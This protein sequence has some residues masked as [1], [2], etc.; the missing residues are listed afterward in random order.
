MICRLRLKEKAKTEAQ[1][2]TEPMA[3]VSKPRTRA[4]VDA[5]KNKRAKAR[6]RQR[7][8][9]ANMSLKKKNARNATRMRNYYRRKQEALN[10]KL[11]LITQNSKFIERAPTYLMRLKAAYKQLAKKRDVLSIT[12][13]A[14]I[15]RILHNSKETS[16]TRKHYKRAPKVN[17][18]VATFYEEQ[19]VDLPGKRS[20]C[21]YSMKPKKVL[22]RKVADV[23]EDF[24]IRHPDVKMSLTTF[25][26]RRPRHVMLSSSRAFL[27][28]L[29]E[30]C[31]NPMLKLDKLN[32]FL[33]VKIRNVDDL[34]E[35]T[36]CGVR[37]YNRDCIDRKCDSCG[38][39]RVVEGWRAEVG[40]NLSKAITWFKWEQS[41]GKGKDKVEKSGTVG[42]LIDELNDEM[43]SLAHHLKT[44]QWQRQQYNDLRENLSPAC[45]VVTIDF[46]E[47]YLCT[48]QNEVQSAHWNYK[49]VSV[50]P[51]VLQYK[52]GPNLITEYKIFLS[53]DL[54]HD[55]AF[56]KFAIQKCCTHLKQ[57]G[58]KQIFLFSDGCSAQYKSK[59]PFAHLTEIA[60]NNPTLTIER[61]FFGSHHGKSLCDSCGGVVKT[62]AT[63]AVKSGREHIQNAEQMFRYCEKLIIDTE[64]E[65]FEK[66]HILRSFELVHTE[67]LDRGVASDTYKT[68]PGTRGLHAIRPDAAVHA[69]LS[70]K[71]FSCFCD[72][73]LQTGNCVNS[74][75]TGMWTMARVPVQTSKAGKRK[76]AP[77]KMSG[78]SST[79]PQSS[80]SQ[81][82][83]N[84]PTKEAS[85][86]T[87]SLSSPAQQVQLDQPA[88]SCSTRSTNQPAQC[89]SS[90]AAQTT[91]KMQSQTPNERKLEFE[92]LQQKLAHASSWDAFWSICRA[93]ALL[94]KYLISLQ[95]LDIDL[96]KKDRSAMLLYPSDAPRFTPIHVYGDGN[97][98]PRCASILA[99]GDEDQFT[100]MRVRIAIEMALHRDIYSNPNMSSVV[101]NLPKKALLY[102]EHFVGQHLTDGVL[103]KMFEDEVMGS[104]KNSQYM[105]ILQVYAIATLFQMSL[106]SI[107][108]ENVGHNV[109]ADCHHLVHPVRGNTSAEESDVGIMF[110]HT[111]GWHGLPAEWQPNHFVVCIPPGIL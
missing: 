14:A 21:R 60:K 6:D 47:N 74:T 57:K 87:H 78:S 32:A 19:S 58:M 4:E 23:Y 16:S 12:K 34:V 76:K 89:S 35:R 39:T 33:M 22:T 52:I 110:T 48:H 59:L 108:P 10:K 50:H 54:L 30:K 84:V 66:K 24:K 94:D 64:S 11:D 111:K 102:S 83:E 88:Q 8:Y 82:S 65:D 43:K 49:Q 90:D 42:Q 36:I 7:E 103:D 104:V 62:R 107:Y 75:F 69:Q 63:N 28:C 97:C 56:A 85:K 79:V 17:D 20:V 72:G 46:A 37:Q 38:V 95:A 61:H 29:C 55:A 70:V 68:L 71:S 3:T 109:R 31:V 2:A 41:E 18:K 53:D 13:L 101:A 44:A 92:Q 15:K 98:L 96:F 106:P 99:F 77:T 73:C 81:S 25:S 100:E 40:N 67:D 27:Q 1:F 26:R 86:S 93:T 45:A 80:A 9:R 5:E 91:R 105:G 51:C